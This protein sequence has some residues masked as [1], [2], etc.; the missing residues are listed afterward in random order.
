MI[1]QILDPRE[2]GRVTF[3]IRRDRPQIR[4][5]ICIC[6][7]GLCLGWLMGMSASP[8]LGI[9]LTAV[10]G[11]AAGLVSVLCGLPGGAEGSEAGKGSVHAYRPTALPLTL[12]VLFL[13]G[14]S[15][16]GLSTR[17]NEWLGPEPKTIA[18]R[19]IAQG[20][21][22]SEAAIVSRLFDRD[23][24]KPA[25]KAADTS[26]ARA[27]KPWL[28]VVEPDLCS[29]LRRYI[30]PLNVEELRRAMQQSGE[31]RIKDFANSVQDPQ[32]LKTVVEVFIC[33]K[34]ASQ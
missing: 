14:G 29:T 22:W 9:V 17:V 2:H 13:V 7:T 16:L 23:N 28:F 25:E 4:E 30:N 32:A 18:K 33:P 20:L 8:V 21:P 27:D 19:W 3:V 11:V 24:P 1:R 34:P 5:L 26:T 15:I 10:L 31:Q 12:L 6:L